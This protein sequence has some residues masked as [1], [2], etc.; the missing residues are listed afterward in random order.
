L[1]QPNLV[2]VAVCAENIQWKR[3]MAGVCIYDCG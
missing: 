3:D 2:A 1:L